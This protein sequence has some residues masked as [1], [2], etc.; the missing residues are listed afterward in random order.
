MALLFITIKVIKI[1][2]PNDKIMPLMLFMLQLTAICKSNVL[3]HETCVGLGQG[4][5][6]IYQCRYARL[7]PA[8]PGYVRLPNTC[9]AA[10]FPT[11]P[12]L[13]LALAVMLNINKWVYFTMRIQC[14]I[15]ILKFKITELRDKDRERQLPPDD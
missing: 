13:F 8:P 6:F 3:P 1:V 7:P 14:H 10:I 5:F 12:T 2:G 9:E 11:I 15:N 4:F